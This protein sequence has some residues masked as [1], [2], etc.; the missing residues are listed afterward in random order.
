LLYLGNA[1][2][3]ISKKMS[4]DKFSG[5]CDA[6]RLGGGGEKTEKLHEFPPKREMAVIRKITSPGEQKFY[7]RRNKISISLKGIAHRDE[8]KKREIEKWRKKRRGQDQTGKKN[9]WEKSAFSLLKKTRGEE[10]KERSEWSQGRKNVHM[11]VR[12]GFQ[13]EDKI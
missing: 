13:E 9:H 12:V 11:R 2:I 6:S 10:K 5:K 3:N 8:R 4:Q 1:Q 7:Q